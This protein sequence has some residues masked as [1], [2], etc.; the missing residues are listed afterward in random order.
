MN[1]AE[2]VNKLKGHETA[3]RQAGMASLYLFGS[4][5]EERAHDNSDVDLF[6]DLGQV[7]SFTL[8]DLINMRE[9]LEALVGAKVDLMSREAIHPRRRDR[10]VKKAYQI[11]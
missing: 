3:L 1:R 5:A 4:V 9:D 2:V 6:F 7:A 11:F 8:F 10:I